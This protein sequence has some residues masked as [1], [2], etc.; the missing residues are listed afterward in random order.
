MVW[1]EGLVLRF[2]LVWLYG[3]VWFS[4]RVLFWFG[5]VWFGLV[6]Y[7]DVVVELFTKTVPIYLISDL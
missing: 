7:F 1:F 3:L 4:I 5:L 6:Y 2:G